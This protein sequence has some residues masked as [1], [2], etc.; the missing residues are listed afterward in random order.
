MT[1]QEQIQI[2]A[3]RNALGVLLA[4]LEWQDN[5]FLSPGQPVAALV[6]PQTMV[7]VE[8]ALELS[9]PIPEGVLKE[10]MVKSAVEKGT[11]G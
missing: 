5:R 6:N 3:L 2:N 8:A 7:R 4:D 11:E 9:A 1:S 10:G